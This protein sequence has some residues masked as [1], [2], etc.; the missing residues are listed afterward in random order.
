MSSFIAFLQTVRADFTADEQIIIACPSQEQVR[1]FKCFQHL[2]GC[3]YTLIH[4]TA[5][6]YSWICSNLYCTCLFQIAVMITSLQL[7]PK[8]PRNSTSVSASPPKQM[9]SCDEKQEAQT[10][11]IEPQNSPRPEGESVNGNT[12]SENRETTIQ[13][14]G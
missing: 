3:Y 6:Q 2:G 8:T 9:V 14:S 1:W 11:N 5:G 4:P 12:V 7:Q 13:S 10:K